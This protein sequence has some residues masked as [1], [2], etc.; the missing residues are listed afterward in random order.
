MEGKFVR[1]LKVIAAILIIGMLGVVLPKSVCA[2]VYIPEKIKVGLFFKDAKIGI[3]TSVANFS[4]KSE[5]GIRVG[6]YKDDEFIV[7]YEELSSNTITVKKDSFFVKT[8]SGISEYNPSSEKCPEGEKTGPYHIKIGENYSDLKSLNEQLQVIKSQGINAYPVFTDTLEIWTGFYTDEDTAKIEI[9][10]ILKSNLGEGVYNVIMPSSS[11]VVAVN[12]TGDTVALCDA[13]LGSL[14]LRS[15]QEDGIPLVKVN[16]NDYRG[17]IEVRRFQSSDMTV[18]NVLPLEDYL[19]GVVPCEIEGVSHSE[20]IKAQA[21][22]ARTYTLNNIGKYK[23]IGF[24]ISNTT[25]CQVYKGYSKE[26]EACNKAIDDT[27]G[28]IITYN[29]TTAQ[30]FYFSSSGGKTEDASNVWGNDFPYLK[31]VEDKYES[32]NSWNYTWEAVYTADKIKQIMLDRNYDLGNILSVEITKTSEAGRVTE[33]TVS[34]TK[35][36]RIYSNSGTRAVLGQLQSQWYRIETDADIHVMGGD[37]NVNKSQLGNR[38]VITSSGIKTIPL[39]NSKLTV[40]AAN[41]QKS[42]ISASP[43]EYR[44]TGKGWGHA[45][46]MSQEGAK[47]MAIAGYKYDDILT[48]YF[49]GT[50]IK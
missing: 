25:Y 11:R 20:A 49:Q 4:V 7:A 13:N 28:K 31:S 22:A 3:D 8:N 2:S 32:G 36:K 16:G 35:N 10:T 46:G 21:V 27:R 9:E 5:K 33:L 18:I 43:S 48:H 45:V 19:Y 17:D 34:G 6:Y 14:R 44:F 39:Q 30:V 1:V 38:K 40:L 50:K 26:N 12:S 47:G 37:S 42:T 29:D 24:D 23:N 41:G 15:M